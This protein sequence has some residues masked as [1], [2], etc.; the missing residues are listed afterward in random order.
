[1]GNVEIEENEKA[2]GRKEER[3]M[4]KL[5]KRQASDLLADT[6]DDVKTGKKKKSD[7]EGQEEEE[8]SAL[9]DAADAV[10]AADASDAADAAN[11]STEKMDVT[12]NENVEEKKKLTKR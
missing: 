8:E 5:K 3:K 1:M 6:K 12:T 9:A 2:T 10:D 11:D 7:G 4:R